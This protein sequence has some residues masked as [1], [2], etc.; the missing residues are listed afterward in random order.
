[1]CIDRFYC[2]KF[3][4]VI[5]D[6]KRTQMQKKCIKIGRH[7]ETFFFLTKSS[8]DATVNHTQAEQDGLVITNL[9][10]RIEQEK[11]T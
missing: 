2:G 5:R 10:Q 3:N 7:K 9:C 4:P 1:M 8:L 11:K 6:L